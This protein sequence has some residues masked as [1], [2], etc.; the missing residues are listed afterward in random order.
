MNFLSLFSGIGGLDLGLERAG[1]RCVS[2]VEIDPFCRKV[3]AKHWPHV[4]RFEDVRMFDPDCINERIDLIAGGFP[5]QDVSTAGTMRGFSGQRSSLYREVIRLVCAVHPRFV[6]MEN[7]AG[8]FVDGRIG[9]VLGDLAAIGFNAE[10]DCIPACALGAHHIRDRVFILAHRERGGWSPSVF[11]GIRRAVGK[12]SDQA[13]RKGAAKAVAS[14]LGGE[15]VS[16]WPDSIESGTDDESDCPR[17]PK[18]PALAEQWIPEPIMDRMV[19]GLPSQLDCSRI[20]ALG[21]AVH[22]QV[23]ELIGRAI[24]TAHA[25]AESEAA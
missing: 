24:L 21:N 1:M 5:C 17:L 3:L 11:E 6:L 20:K 13:S 9:T 8:L 18:R 23:A 15:G 14:L 4:P 22:P 19:N 25:A 7:V 10:W 2:Q 16:I 12:T